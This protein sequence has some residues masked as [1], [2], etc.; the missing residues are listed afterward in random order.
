MYS[1]LRTETLDFGENKYYHVSSFLKLLLS[2]MTKSREKYPNFDLDVA[3]KKIKLHD[4]DYGGDSGV[5]ILEIK[6]E[7]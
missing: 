6:N 1:I 3:L 4:L 7:L 5:E 2:E